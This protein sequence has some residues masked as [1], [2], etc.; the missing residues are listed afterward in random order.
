[1]QLTLKRAKTAREAVETMGEFVADH[2]YRSSGESFC[3]GDPSEAWIMEMF[4]T[5]PGGK[6]AVWV[7]LKVPD[8]YI[9]SYANKPRIDSFPSMIPTTASTPR[10]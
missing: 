7:A 9:S 5:G 10:T 6:G 1:M 3:I 8:G 2:G 4:G